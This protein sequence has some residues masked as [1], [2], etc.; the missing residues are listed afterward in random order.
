M[1]PRSD[2]AGSA[3]TGLDTIARMSVS[4]LTTQE[5]IDR[6]LTALEVIRELS[7]IHISEPTRPY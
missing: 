6:A 3:C 5:E 1:N 2:R 4:Y 7:L